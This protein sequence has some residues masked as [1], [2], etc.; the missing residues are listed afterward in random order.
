MKKNK[1]YVTPE[2]KVMK[3]DV[4]PLLVNSGVNAGGEGGTW[5]SEEY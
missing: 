5:Q 3:V 2:V 4:I 1:E